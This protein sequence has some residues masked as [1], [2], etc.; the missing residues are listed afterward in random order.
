METARR[1]QSTTAEVDRRA[2]VRVKLHSAITA[3]RLGDDNTFTIE[4]ASIAG[5]SIYSPVPFEPGSSYHFR[6]SDAASQVV[7]V[8]GVCRY[9]RTLDDTSP[10]SFLV[11][12]QLDSP[13]S[14]RVPIILG[15]SPDDAP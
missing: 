11:G 5:F 13:P 4:D 10:P 7:L 1:E 2:H 15:V 8:G 9:C 3:Q 12:F 14:R 6:L